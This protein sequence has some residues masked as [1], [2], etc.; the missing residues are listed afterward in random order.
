MTAPYNRGGFHATASSNS[1]EAYMAFNNSIES[2]GIWISGDGVT[3]FLEIFCP[4]PVIIWRIALEPIQTIPAWN[5]SASNNISEFTPI[6]TS[7]ASLRET[8]TAPNFF[9][10]STT[11]A[12]R[13]YRVTIPEKDDGLL[14]GIKMMQL[15][16]YYT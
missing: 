10:I 5:L 8:V 15:Y 4:E 9:N 16:V 7:T 3:A 1:D 11:T 12:Y 13:F 14:I 6:F 2:N